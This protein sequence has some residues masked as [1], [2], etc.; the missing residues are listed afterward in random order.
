MRFV[1]TKQAKHN[2]AVCTKQTKET[3]LHNN[4]VCTKPARETNFNR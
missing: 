2:N 1:I 4:G 3:E